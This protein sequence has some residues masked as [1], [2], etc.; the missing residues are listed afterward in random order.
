MSTALVAGAT[1]CVGAHVC[2]AFLD[3]G[4]RV[5]GLTRGVR[6]A[7]RPTD[8]D[9]LHHLDLVSC[10]PAELAALLDDERVD[11]VVNAT[12]AWGDDQSAMDRANVTPVDTLLAAIAGSAA[13]PRLVQLGT[14]HEYGPV[15]PGTAIDER[16]PPRP[17]NPYARAKLAASE[18]VLE[19]VRRDGLDAVV[20]RLANTVGPQPSMQTFFGTLAVSLARLEAGSPPMPITVADAR[21]DYVDPRDAADA[22]VRAAGSR[23][24]DPLVNIGSGQ[25]YDIRAMV[26]DLVAAAGLPPGVV[27]EQAG[28]VAGTVAG[29]DWTLV[30][31]TR[32]REL[33]GW[34]PR[35]SMPET[36]ADLYRSVAPA[37]TR[38]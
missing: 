1:G 37:P 20:V 15:S 8:P 10:Q 25:A 16:V 5:V 32:A 3:A 30:D 18:R 28:T 21:R 23:A 2:A 14:V 17:V 26:G 19:A 4:Y 34:A 6:P 31:A 33:L 12:L 36:L 24:A 35:R 29:A 38:G 27:E 13:A 7:G 11:V 22:I 9:V